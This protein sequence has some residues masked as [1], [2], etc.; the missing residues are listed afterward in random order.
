MLL[1]DHQK[2]HP[3]RDCIRHSLT[4]GPLKVGTYGIARGFGFRLGVRTGD[5]SVALL[6]TTILICPRSLSVM[7]PAVLVAFHAARRSKKGPWVR[8]SAEMPG[9]KAPPLLATPT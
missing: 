3:K 1:V 6:G 7:V 5:G 8:V 2:K 4:P 9:P